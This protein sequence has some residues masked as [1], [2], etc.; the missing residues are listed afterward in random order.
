MAAESDIIFLKRFVLLQVFR[1]RTVDPMTQTQFRRATLLV[2]LCL[3]VMAPGKRV[4]V[5]ER[6]TPQ[7]YEIKRIPFA[8]GEV[9]EYAVTWNGIPAADGSAW[10]ERSVQGAKECYDFKLITKTNSVLDILWKMR[11]SGQ[12]TV[13]AKTL[14]PKQHLFVHQENDRRRR[15][16]STFDHERKLVECVREVVEKNRTDRVRFSCEFA[17]DPISAPYFL[18]CLDWRAG[19]LRQLEMVENNARY[20]FTVQAVGV[21]EITVPAGKFRAVKLRPVLTRLGGVKKKPVAAKEAEV[22]VSD[23]DYHIPLRLKTAS[24]VG[25]IYVDLANFQLASGGRPPSLC[26]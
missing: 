1:D 9:F 5:Q 26:P 7:R 16:T 24:F 11:D 15:Y 25:H 23:D 10:V 13:D 12:S 18:R 19:D 6:E 21:E 20:L 14:L 4:A 17:F 3:A 2:L 22:W 8:P